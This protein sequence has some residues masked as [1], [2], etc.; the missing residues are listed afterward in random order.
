MGRGEDDDDE[1]D[2]EDEDN[3]RDPLGWCGAGCLCVVFGL[4]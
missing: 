3:F 2:D 1:D 4:L